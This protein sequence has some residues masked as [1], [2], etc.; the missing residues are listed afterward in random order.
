MKQ[1]RASNGGSTTRTGGG[2]R[3]EATE[4]VLSKAM[5]GGTGLIEARLAKRRAAA[6]A[7]AA[8]TAAS[9]EAQKEVSGVSQRQFRTPARAAC[10]VAQLATDERSALEQ[11]LRDHYIDVNLAYPG[12]RCVSID[13]PVLLFPQ[14]VPAG[15]CASLIEEAS[16]SGLMQ[17]SSFGEG[18]AST[19]S[20]SQRRTSHTMLVDGSASA[21]LRTL[22]E[23]VQRR[24]KEV[25]IG[26]PSWGA[27]AA[28]PPSARHHALEPLQL[29]S[30]SE[31]QQFL[32]H[33]DA[34]PDAYANANGFNRSA[35]ALLYL[36][37]NGTGGG[38][39]GGETQFTAVPGGL[40][41]TPERGSLLLFFPSRR[42]SAVSELW[43][44]DGATLHAARPTDGTWQKWV[45][46][47]WIAVGV[48]G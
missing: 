24:V 29:C 40:S 32:E 26:V 34:F 15:E 18:H 27:P 47:Q 43:Q 25:L 21:S 1:A 19:A 33:E 5:S 23:G 8:Q 41:V 10:E 14:L 2:A 7:A 45:A 48:R 20:T 35:T 30:Y 22:S 6:A 39:G 9:S 4:D 31:G 38:V 13:P 46:Q 28:P 12:V 11:V 17:Q 44:A 37:D 42:A 36:N 3:V 16:A